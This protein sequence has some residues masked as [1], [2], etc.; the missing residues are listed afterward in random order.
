MILGDQ[1]ADPADG[2]SYNSA[3]H[4]LLH[5]PRVN[6]TATPR[7]EGA[8]AAAK[9]QQGVNLQHQGDPAHDTAD[10]SDRAVGN[11]RADYVLPS[12][13]LTVHATGVFWPNAAPEAELVTCS[14]HRLVWLDL[15]FPNP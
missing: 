13:D 1:N 15:S 6:G 2:A 8:T 11:L 9:N 14:D 3:I 5:H 4:Q 10:F 12:R 7:S